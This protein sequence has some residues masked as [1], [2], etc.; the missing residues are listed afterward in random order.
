MQI[1]RPITLKKDG[2]Q[3]RN[4]KLQAKGRK[5]FFETS[6]TSAG[7]GASPGGLHYHAAAAAAHQQAA[8]AAAGMHDFFKS[9]LVDS[10][11]SAAAIASGG[12]ACGASSS[13]S[14]AGSS[15]SVS[16][17]SPGGG[18]L[19]SPMSQYYAPAGYYGQVGQMI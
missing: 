16:G 7:M 17:A 3:T 5:R 11:F 2:I 8:A 19:S 15:V 14:A 4:R 1:S 12:Y 13:S 9:P 6:P 18:Y 10:R